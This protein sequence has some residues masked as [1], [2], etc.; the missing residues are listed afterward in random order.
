LRQDILVMPSIFDDLTFQKQRETLQGFPWHEFSCSLDALQ[1]MNICIAENLGEDKY[2][3]SRNVDSDV[4]PEVL[5]YTLSLA[6]IPWIDRTL[7]MMRA[8]RDG[9]RAELSEKKHIII[10]AESALEHFERHIIPSWLIEFPVSVKMSCSACQCVAS[11]KK[12]SS[13]SRG[14]HFRV[15]KD[16]GNEFSN[17]QEVLNF[18]VHFLLYR[19][20]R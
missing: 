15:Y 13:S 12:R 20:L 11:D 1:L 2:D 16:H 8:H 19:K 18:V 3:G 14:L 4:I 9:I 10:G 17:L 7:A 6:K 5:K